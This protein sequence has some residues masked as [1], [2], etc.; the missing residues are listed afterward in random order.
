MCTHLSVPGLVYLCESP[1]A[2]L[3]L[4]L[5]WGQGEKTLQTCREHPVY[6]QKDW[7]ISAAA[8]QWRSG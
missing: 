8:K 3:T 2:G 1:A 6:A 7:C 4:L 5:A